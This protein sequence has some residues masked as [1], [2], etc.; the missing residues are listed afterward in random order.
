VS[1]ALKR[2]GCKGDNNN[3][4][5]EQPLV[6]Q[7][8]VFLGLFRSVSILSQPGVGRLAASAAED[9]DAV[10][11]L[12]SSDLFCRL[13]TVHYGQLNVHEDQMETTSLPLCHGFLAVHG[14]L[15]SYLETL[16]E[17]AQDT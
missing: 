17:S 10:D 14:P 3:G 11:A 4:A 8:V 2:A 15:P 7:P 13:Q 6:A 1:V 5:L 16:H 12:K 9:T